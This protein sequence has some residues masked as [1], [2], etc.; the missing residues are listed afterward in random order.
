M[1][2]RVT[3][4]QFLEFLHC[5]LSSL[6]RAWLQN[7]P[8]LR[9]F[10]FFYL[11]GGVF[12]EELSLSRF[13][14]PY[15]I[16]GPRGGWGGTPRTPQIFLDLISVASCSQFA[17]L[18]KSHPFSPSGSLWRTRLPTFSNCVVIPLVLFP[19]AARGLLLTGSLLVSFSF[20]LTSGFFF[21]R[22]RYGRAV[23]RCVCHFPRFS[24]D[25]FRA[26]TAAFG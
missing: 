22:A 3:R 24:N 19:T 26:A 9:P 1:S 13:L 2:I 18:L 15:L 4:L 21:T 7:P 17:F 8:G 14:F 23:Q 11:V 16:Y 6:S 20:L 12:S 5:P 10:P 25:P